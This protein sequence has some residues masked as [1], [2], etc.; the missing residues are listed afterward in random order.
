MSITLPVV[1][2]HR[3]ANHGDHFEAGFLGN[4]VN[5]L[6]G[7][8]I[9]RDTR[10]ILFHSHEH[11]CTAMNIGSARVKCTGLYKSLIFLYRKCL[12]ML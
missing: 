11:A 7:R 2:V 12:C 10:I 1:G 6:S 8:R 9:D 3:I 5:F 4:P